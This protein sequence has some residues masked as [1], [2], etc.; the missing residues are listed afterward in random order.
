MAWFQKSHDGS[1]GMFQTEEIL[2][3]RFTFLNSSKQFDGPVRWK[4]PEFSYL[5]DFNLHYFEYLEL[6]SR[7]AKIIHRRKLLRSL[8]NG[9]ID[10]NPSPVRPA[11]HPYPTLPCAQSIG[12]NSWSI[13]QSSPKKKSCGVYIPNSSFWKKNLEGHLQANH[14]SSKMATHW[15]SEGFF[16]QGKDANALVGSR[17]APPEARSRS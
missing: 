14:P 1:H 12:S 15:Y 7:I 3:G 10:A 16:F 13:T 4:N 2:K 11:W 5:W 9:W 17:A 6:P 8:L